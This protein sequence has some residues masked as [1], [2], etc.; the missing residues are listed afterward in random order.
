M[1]VAAEFGIWIGSRWLPRA[2]VVVVAVAAAVA[3]VVGDARAARR[4][5]SLG[6]KSCP[7]VR[8]PVW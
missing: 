7:L 1:A 2:V 5:G 8:A 4:T 3:D 6:G